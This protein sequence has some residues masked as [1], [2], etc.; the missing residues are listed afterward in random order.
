MFRRSATGI[1]F[2]SER[3]RES[4]QFS[5]AA[6]PLVLLVAAA[7]RVMLNLRLDETML[8][9]QKAEFEFLQES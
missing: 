1:C 7:R 2:L 6:P 4:S 9:H 8:Q 5:T 3:E